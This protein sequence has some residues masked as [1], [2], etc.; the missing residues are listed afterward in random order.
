[1]TRA[2]R[3]DVR[4]L[5]R[6]ARE[7]RRGRADTT[8][9]EVLSDAYI[10][11]FATTMLSAMAISAIHQTRLS[12]ADSC[13]TSECS[14]A[15]FSSTWVCL[16]A[17]LAVTLALARVLGPV[18][19]S[20]AEGS[21]L[22]AT[23][24]DRAAVLRPRLGLVAAIS[25]LAAAVV[26]S[27][28][29]TL[30]GF[31][32]PAIGLVAA[33][34]MAS[35]IAAAML[36]ALAQ[37]RGGWIVRIL[38][39]LLGTAT[40]VALVFIASDVM[41]SAPTSAPWTAVTGATIAGAIW[42]GA[43]GLVI[44]G[45]RNLS[46]I[47]RN[48]LVPGGALLAN[49]SG[50]LAGLDLTMM[51]DILVAQK[52][53][54]RSTVKP[55]RSGPKGP[56]ALVWRD[57]IRLRRS[58]PSLLILA[59]AVVV[60]YLVHAVDLRT[61][62]VLAGALTLFVTG[63]PLCSALRTTSRNAGLVRC[64]PMPA[65][66]VRGACLVVPAAV[67]LLWSLAALPAVHAGTSATWAASISIAVAMGMTALAAMAR[68]LLAPPPS[69]AQSLVSSPAGGIPPGLAFSLLRGFDVL[70]LAT[71]PILISPTSTGAFVSLLLSAGVLGI[72]VRRD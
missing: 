43:L 7:W 31:D 10:A 1:M 38:A 15:R 51:Y 37:P 39:W 30:A 8:L 20:P 50:A 4:E 36:A 19:V 58:V 9:M 45:A 12:I 5:R 59:G 65:A 33:A 55:V 46:R 29:S 71:A 24:V 57:V 27:I 49:L 41:P 17:M 21:W 18:Q 61:L 26:G 48:R 44:A 64:F 28:A 22:L 6:Q 60:P 52:W 40:W 66:T 72:V 70:V 2:S 35:G 56:W 62:V 53:L 42:I 25:A 47:H 32:P 63:V 13:T 69:Y 54:I 16:T 68:W 14:D 11:L 67:T 34:A 3:R 23:P